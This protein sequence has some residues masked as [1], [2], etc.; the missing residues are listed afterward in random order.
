MKSLI[1]NIISSEPFTVV[2]GALIFLIGPLNLQL[3][4]LLL[5]IAIDIAFGIQVAIKEKQFKWKTLF[6]KAKRKL[7]IYGLWISMFH[8]FDMVTGLP[9]SAR[10]AVIVMLAGM[11]LMSAIKNTAKLGHNQLADALEEVYLALTRQAQ[12]APQE[13]PS[14]AQVDQKGGGEHGQTPVDGQSKETG[15]HRGNRI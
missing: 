12:Q 15:D 9:D 3:A 4:Y 8:S 10:W 6:S 13:T 14:Q 11:E 7:I 2:K 1:S 5:A